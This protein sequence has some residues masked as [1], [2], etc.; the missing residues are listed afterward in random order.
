MILNGIVKLGA[1]LDFAGSQPIE[2]GIVG[3]AVDPGGKRRLALEP[4]QCFPCFEKRI[5]G[6]VPSI[7][8][9]VDHGDNMTIDP[10]TMARDQHIKRGGVTALASFHENG[11]C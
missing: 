1:A 11:V 2:G 7:G 8:F 9:A 4:W 10:G 5:L 3:D 6:Q